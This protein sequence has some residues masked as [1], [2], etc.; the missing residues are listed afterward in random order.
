[1]WGGDARVRLGNEDLPVPRKSP[2]SPFTGGPKGPREKVSKDTLGG[3]WAPPRP[4]SEA[5]WE[6]REG[7][8]T[9]RVVRRSRRGSRGG[10]EEQ[11]R[12]RRERCRQ[13]TMALTYVPLPCLWNIWFKNK[14]VTKP[15]YAF[16]YYPGTWYSR[17][18][19]SRYLHQ[20]KQ[21]TMALTY[22]PLPWLWN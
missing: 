1:M 6:C 20:N 15:F 16:L 8:P 2:K 14:K 9:P 3:F 13:A 12:S 21:M 5:G 18:W 4:R 19:Y 11:R 17:T 7:L 10:A 22:L